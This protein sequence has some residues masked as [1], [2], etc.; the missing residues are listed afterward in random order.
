MLGL[1]RARG[2]VRWAR[3]WAPYRS[4]RS[5][6]EL[7][8]P[9]NLL[10]PLASSRLSFR[11]LH[12]ASRNTPSTSPFSYPMQADRRG[13]SAGMPKLGLGLRPRWMS[14]SDEGKDAPG[15]EAKTEKKKAKQFG[16]KVKKKA[17]EGEE[18]KGEEDA[19]EGD[20]NRK[21]FMT[22]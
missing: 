20:E 11:N 17:A 10:N 18:K 14:T 12:I 9:K 5:L 3:A 22:K 4:Y 1:R 21:E 15:A 6:S 7:H 8:Y 19:G 2:S 16:A 13:L